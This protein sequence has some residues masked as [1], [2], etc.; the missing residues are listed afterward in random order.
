MEILFLGE[1]LKKYLPKR[2]KFHPKPPKRLR[3]T[4]NKCCNLL[5]LALALALSPPRDLT[6]RL[7]PTLTEPE[8]PGL[9]PELAGRDDISRGEEFPVISW[10]MVVSGY[11][12]ASL[13]CNSTTDSHLSVC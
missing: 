10:E 13:V 2:L 4:R 1:K 7:L 12:V 5:C 8:L 3:K 11:N 6:L 9:E